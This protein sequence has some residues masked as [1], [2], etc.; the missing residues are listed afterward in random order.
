MTQVKSLT[1]DL[2]HTGLLRARA[3]ARH[4]SPHLH[5]THSIVLIKSG[6]ARIQSARWTKVVGAGDV[7]F[8]NPFEVHAAEDIREPVEYETLYPS[9][10]FISGCIAE[11]NGSDTINIQ[12]DVIS[13]TRQT[14][15]LAE[16]LSAPLTDNRAIE[17]ALGNLLRTCVFSTE[18]RDSSFRS[19]AFRA[20]SFI[21]DNYSLSMRTNDL[22]IKIGVHQSHFIRAFKAATGIAPQLYIRQVRVAKAHDLICAGLD[23][24]DVAQIVG[25]CDQA[26]LTREFKKVFG[27]PPGALSRHISIA[28]RQKARRP[29]I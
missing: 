8:F 26:H 23:L 22:A 28:C 19:V 3:T 12:S 27:V 21:R 18:S 14:R 13:P 10:E 5:S 25:F 20:C 16:A 9:K 1:F 6:A 11:G 24:S 2:K 29:G 4:F 15:E 17:E 7:F